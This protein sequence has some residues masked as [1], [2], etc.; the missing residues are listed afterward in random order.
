MVLW[1]VFD[2]VVLVVWIDRLCM[3][4]RL[5]WI[6]LRV[7]FVVWIIEMLLRVLCEVWL[8]LL[9]WVFIFFEMVMLVVLLVELL[10]WKF[11]DNCCIDFCRLVLVL[12]SEC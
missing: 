12:N 10:M 9:I 11:E 5:D 2:R 7:F 1:L 8:R 3:C 6:L 4:W